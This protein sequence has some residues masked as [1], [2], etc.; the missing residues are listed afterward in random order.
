ME[1]KITII[2]T[3]RLILRRYLKSDLQ[4]LYEYLSDAEVVK[5]EPYQ[6][7]N[8]SEV[9][10]NLDWRISTDEMIAVELKANG[11]MIGN[12]Y[13]GKRDFESLEIGYVFNK[14]YWGKGYAKESCS[15]LIQ[16]SFKNGV[17][18]IFAECDPQNSNSW[19][20]LEALGFT[21]EAYLKQ[22]VYFWKDND[23]NPIWKDTFIYAILNKSGN[24]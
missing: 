15:A 19:K 8:M 18:R 20:L 9:E 14:E 22:N 13:L 24:K 7:M 3:D 11:K 1:D 17:H 21:R 10:N 6:P 5:Y 4:D 23:N 16:Q 2:E 12:V